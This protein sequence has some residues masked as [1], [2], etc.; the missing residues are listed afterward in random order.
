LKNLIKE[1]RAAGVNLEKM[2]VADMESV[3]DILNEKDCVLL[4]INH[5]KLSPYFTNDTGKSYFGL[6]SNDL[7]EEGF[8]WFMR[9]I[10]PEDLPVIHRSIAHFNSDS[11]QVFKTSMRM[12]NHLGMWRWVYSTQKTLT[13]DASGKTEFLIVQ[14]YDIEELIEA[15]SNSKGGN[16]YLRKLKRYNTLT[17]REKEVLNLVAREMTSQEIADQLFI[18]PSTVHTHRKHI[19]RKLNAKTSLG[20]VQYALFFAPEE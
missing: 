4:V 13:Q 18:E 16:A 12:K 7:S 11:M 1:I 6:P 5:A 3:K 19:I 14:F 15:R 9:L 10:H 2:T 20:L 17:G 8:E